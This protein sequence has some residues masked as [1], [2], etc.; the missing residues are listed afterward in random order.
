MNT[1]TLPQAD[2]LQARAA[3]STIIEPGDTVA[4]HLV[5]ALGPVAAFEAMTGNG[6]Q[7][8]LQNAG[9]D[10][11]PAQEAIARWTPRVSSSE[12]AANLAAIKR[13]NVTLIDPD[14]IPALADLGTRRPVALY[15]RGTASLLTSPRPISWVGARASTA[16]GE[17]QTQQIVS[18]LAQHQV[19]II[20]GAAY[21]IEGAAHRAALHAG[22][23]TVAAVAGGL[24]RPYPAGHSDLIG[25]IAEQGAAI[26]EVPLT[27]PPTK[28]RF[29]AR[30]RVLAALGRVTIVAE[31]GIRSAT[32]STAEHAAT[33]RRAV[34]ALPGPLGSPASSGCHRLIREHG[35]TLITSADDVL[36][37]LDGK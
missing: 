14:T 17:F 30:N 20:S 15:V 5:D 27:A 35:A 23:P 7:A 1:K 24:S 33:L 19:T 16:Y 18:D 12:I 36:A 31:A 28:W 11:R 26:S 6:L 9:V 2:M 8:A 25:R 32:I 37:L 22:I 29:Q 21:G 4:G 3:I 13:A 10:E 34:G